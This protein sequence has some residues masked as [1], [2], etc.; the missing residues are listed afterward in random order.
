MP[1]L[2]ACKNV[3]HVCKNVEHGGFSRFNEILK[4]LTGLVFITSFEK[5]QIFLTIKGIFLIMKNHSD[6]NT[7]LIWRILV[8]AWKGA[9]CEYFTYFRGSFSL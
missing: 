5:L 3:K 6:Q 8:A 7:L 2:F 4:I 1:K 9:G